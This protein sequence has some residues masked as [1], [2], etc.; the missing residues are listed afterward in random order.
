MA[1]KL[2]IATSAALLLGACQQGDGAAHISIDVSGFRGSALTAEGPATERV[3]TVTLAVTAMDLATPVAVTLD[4]ASGSTT[5]DVPAGPGRQFTVEVL[6]SDTTPALPTYWGQ[7]VKDLA[8][9]TTTVLTLPAYSAGQLRGSVTIPNTALPDP[10]TLHVT[11]VAPRPEVPSEFNIAVSGGRFQ[12]TLPIGAYHVKGGV[13]ID[14]VA[15]E[16]NP[17]LQAQVQQGLS[18]TIELALAP[19]VDTTSV[20]TP[21]PAVQLVL[22]A[23]PSSVQAGRAFSITVTAL[24]DAGNIATDYVGM[25]TFSASDAHAALPSD[26]AFSSSD[27]GLKIFDGEVLLTTAGVHTLSVSDVA[28][29][30]LRGT[31]SGITVRAAAGAS[32]TLTSSATSAAA[33]TPLSLVVT[34]VDAFGNTA[35]D[36]TGTVRFTS[37]DSKAVLPAAYTFAVADAG[38]HI[39]DGVLLRTAGLQTV[40]LQ[41]QDGDSLSVSLSI[42]AAATKTLRLSAPTLMTVGVA[43]NFSIKAFDAFDNAALYT[44]TVTFT[45]SD[46]GAVLPSD[47]TFVAADAGLHV[48]VVTMASHGSQTITATDTLSPD[49]ATTQSIT[50]QAG[51]ASKLVLTALSDAIV[52]GVATTVQLTAYDV[53]NNVVPNYAGTVHFTASDGQAILPADYPFVP[54]DLGSKTFSLTLLTAAVQELVVRDVNNAALAATLTNIGVAPGPAT[55]L[56]VVSPNPVVAGAATSVTVTAFDAANNVAKAYA[57]TVHFSSTDPK[58]ALPNDI[59]LSGKNGSQTVSVTLKTAGLQTLT[60]QD[61]TL[62]ITGT[63]TGITVGPAAA[64]T[65]SLSMASTVTAGTSATLI[66]SVRD[67]YNN[68]VPSYLGTV[69]FT[70]LDANSTLPTGEHFTLGDAGTHTTNLVFKTAGPGDVTAVATDLGSVQITGSAS[71]TVQA[72]AA[73]SLE[74]TGL[75]PSLTAGTASTVTVKARDAYG[76]IATTFAHAVTLTSSDLAATLPADYAFVGP[77]NGQKT[78]AGQ[79]TLTTANASPHTVTVTDTTTPGV[80]GTASVTVQPGSAETLQVI[81]LS[82]APTAGAPNSVTVKAL[83][84]WSNVAKSYTGQVRFTASDAQAVLPGDATFGVGDAGVKTFGSSVTFKTAGPQSVTVT[85]TTLATITG[86]QTGITVGAAAAATLS[87]STGS[88]AIAGASPTLT[89]IVRDPFNNLAPSYTG[90]VQFSSTDAQAVLPGNYTF[91]GSDAGT[92]TFTPTFKTAGSHTVT[93]TDTVQSSVQ[94]TSASITV[95]PAAASQLAV[96][97][98]ANPTT[99]C[100]GGSALVRALDLYGNVIPDYAGVVTLSATDGAATFAPTNHTFTPA[101]LGAFTFTVTLHTG[102]WNVTATDGAA[103]TG[104][105]NGISVASAAAASL[106]VTATD[107]VTAGDNG[108]VTVHAKDA[109]GGTASSYLGTVQLTASD[110]NAAV[111]ANENFSVGDAGTHVFAPVVLKTAGLT[112]LTATDQGN[113]TLTGS[114]SVTVDAAN[115]QSLELTGL[116]ASLAAGTASTLT[117]KARDFYGNLSRNYVGTVRVTSSDPNAIGVPADYAFVGADNGQKT[118]SGPVT[119]TTA[120]ATQTVTAKDTINNSIAQAVAWV[121]VTPGQATKLD[122]TLSNGTPTA[123]QSQT[124]TVVVQDAYGNKAT[125]FVGSVSLASGDPNATLPASYS[126]TAGGD[127]GEH[128]FGGLILRTAGAQ[129]V[130]ATSGVLAG[131]SQTATVAAGL[132]NQLAFFQQPPASNTACTPLAT[133]VRINVEDAYGNVVPGAF[134]AITLSLGSATLGTQSA[135]GGTA[136]FSTLNIRHPGS[137]LRLKADAPGLGT[138]L[139]STFNVGTPA[140]PVIS[141]FSAPGGGGVMALTYWVSQA[142]GDKVDIEVQYDPFTTAFATRR[143]ATLASVAAPTPTSPGVNGVSTTQAGLQHTFLWNSGANLPNQSANVALRIRASAD[144]VWGTPATVTNVSVQNGFAFQTA[145]SPNTTAN[146]ATFAAADLDLDGLMDFVVADGPAKKFQ[147]YHGVAG[148][149]FQVNPNSVNNGNTTLSF[150]R[151]ALGDVNNDGLQDLVG[152]TASNQFAYALGAN[153]LTFGAV[154]SPNSFALNC[155][156]SA[157]GLADINRDGK[158]DVVADC[159]G[160]SLPNRGVSFLI[161]NATGFNP[162][163]MVTGGPTNANALAFGDMNKDG[164]IDVVTAGANTA[165]VFLN[166]NDPNG[167]LQTGASYSATGIFKKVALGD[168]NR[169]GNL[170]AVLI[171]ASD[172]VLMTGNPNGVL[173]Y[174][175]TMSAGS[176][177]NDVGLA[178]IDRDGDLDVVLVDGS[179]GAISVYLGN[180]T[181]SFVGSGGPAMQTGAIALALADTNHDARLDIL[182]YKPGSIQLTL[183]SQVG[184]VDPQIAAA[185]ALAM[186]EIS[187]MAV[188]DVSGDAKPDLVVVSD[189]TQDMTIWLGLGDGSVT[190]GGT[191]SLGVQ[192]QAPVLLYANDDTYLDVAVPL[193]GTNVVVIYPNDGLGTLGAP[194]TVSVSSLT[195]VVASDFNHDHCDDLVVLDALLPQAQVAL[196]RCSTFGFTAAQ[197]VTLQAAATDVVVVDLNSDGNLDLVTVS[198]SANRI[199]SYL[200]DGTGA[201]S[202]DSSQSVVNPNRLSVGDLNGDSRPDVV[203]SNVGANTVSMLLTQI[204]G[205]LGA[206]STYAS[207]IIP[208]GVSIADI[209]RDT[210]PDVVVNGSGEDVLALLHGNGGGGIDTTSRFNAGVQ[211]TALLLADLN[212]DSTLD[213]LSLSDQ[214]NTITINEG[215]SEAAAGTFYAPLVF[216]TGANPAV[217]VAVDVDRDGKLDLAIPTPAGVTLLH[218]TGDANTL[219]AWNTIDGGGGVRSHLVAADFNGDGRI[220]MASTGPGTNDVRVLFNN[221]GDFTTLTASS[222]PSMSVAG[223]ALA[224]ADF[225]EDGR[226]DILTAAFGTGLT[227]LNGNPNANAMT[228]YSI[229]AVPTP[230]ALAVG[231]VNNDGRLDVVVLASDY[232]VY[233]GLGTGGAGAATFDFSASQGAGGLNYSTMAPT[234]LAL[235]DLDNNGLLDVLVM[236]QTS[237]TLGV[238]QYVYNAGVRTPQAPAFMSI[239]SAQGALTTLDFNSDGN[240]DLVVPTQT[241]TVTLFMGVGNGTFKMDTPLAAQVGL[242]ASGVIIADFNRDGRKDLAT[243]SYQNSGSVSIMLG[244]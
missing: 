241:G 221:S 123:G 235:S 188:G 64:A 133:P 89:V 167:G 213:V 94:G 47:Y 230:L 156:A 143:I 194:T 41:R 126:Y 29:R 137:G 242:G 244:R 243:A 132:A 78:L 97:G 228:S 203:V 210:Y 173:Q 114:I 234:G 227:L 148:G 35:T 85:D 40:T 112:T 4:A 98:V 70:A 233:E 8:P 2:V 158:L 26:Y 196:S 232:H 223:F 185:R 169:D 154:S 180:G 36:D 59:S 195:R 108:S 49:R 57:G 116:P 82:A 218:G 190:A 117:V 199:D 107:P 74:L 182:T 229:T 171:T 16:L 106:H 38:Q 27:A 136:T 174:A 122:L 236:S 220:D 216:S 109:C 87:L 130:T 15:Y 44:G 145:G 25:V 7:T 62:G 131:S 1:T 214:A 189:V 32:M 172:L 166:T 197:T 212:G 63:Q 79:V 192:P 30:T 240:M 157:L 92:K 34:S 51:S 239:P 206:P 66:V 207:P 55:L 76:N 140:P 226:A 205:T 222:Y 100:V 159:N 65:L 163:V 217:P 75:P 28:K 119:L 80:F 191:V 99:A 215:V 118:L 86:A 120:N 84:H 11:A 224:A 10:C 56:K 37:S 134:D 17:A 53:A 103:L 186:G 211:P 6:R 73:T 115:T 138:I 21:G 20:H 61:S 161:R 237:P 13:S 151:L 110:P 95:T 208:S 121:T 219:A 46:G 111:P 105:Q 81:G 231:D 176:Q 24:D 198:A 168:V 68:A 91:T 52:S 177:F 43:Q 153:V 165:T 201:F 58:G 142:C 93:A 125:D 19:P 69:A 83:D 170:D 225:N 204:G 101:D 162:N 71:V 139:S 175:N 179:N 124:C 202:A 152:Q 67:A 127:A 39:F 50:V 146:Y 9:G 5:F 164:W 23:L 102:T 31:S 18:T 22:S 129:T 60:A 144:G 149:G 3:D 181:T 33:D 77:D 184:L 12:Q 45:S 135:S 183:G 42:T 178:D 150:V 200:G 14:G 113:G 72:G 209:D 193:P 54:S 90:T 147:G 238:T 104:S 88:T 128:T 187:G 141:S 155:N 48:F 160:T 96:S